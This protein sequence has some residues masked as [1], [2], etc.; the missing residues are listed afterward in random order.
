[1]VHKGE[2]GS[3]KVQISVHMV[4]E[5]PLSAINKKFR[6]FRL[7][8][9][10]L[11]MKICTENAINVLRTGHVQFIIVRHPLWADIGF[12]D[13]SALMYQIPRSW[14]TKQSTVLQDYQFAALKERDIIVY[15]H[16]FKQ[17]F[18]KIQGPIIIPLCR[19]LAIL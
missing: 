10:L 9:K 15:F 2:G 13:R 19:K 4:Y 7:N 18:Y 3:K 14:P 17:N 16:C 5:W 8:K 6:R 1:M 11:S 12:V